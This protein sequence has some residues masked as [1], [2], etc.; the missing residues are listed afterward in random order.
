MKNSILKNKKIVYL[1]TISLLFTF[2][3]CSKLKTDVD[4]YSYA[5][6]FQLGTRISKDKIELIVSSF[7][8][9]INQS[10]ES[11]KSQYTDEEISLSMMQV[12]QMIQGNKQLKPNMTIFS[13]GLG[14]NTAKQFKQMDIALSPE[15]YKLGLN[16]ASSGEESKLKEEET[17]KAFEQINEIAKKKQEATAKENLVKG[18]EFLAKNKKEK[19]VIVTDSGLQ[20]EIIE[21]GRGRSPKATDMVQVHYRGTLIDGKEF[22][23]SYK[24]NKPADFALN[25]VI[26]G[27]TEGIQLMRPGAKY[28]FTIPSALAYGPRGNRGIPGNS[29]LI[30]EVE[31][32]KVLPAPKK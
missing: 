32:L 31:F 22:D 26:K 7:E 18:N 12:Q 8:E 4:K 24:R 19:G 6:G 27:W 20:Y 3:S 14:F 16:D 2:I 11:K 25:G 21:K 5:L 1:V 23:S 28:K 13:Y 17:K 10:T 29:V 9:G 15:T 30:F